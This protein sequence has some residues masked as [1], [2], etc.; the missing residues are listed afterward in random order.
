MKILVCFALCLSLM[1][2]VPATAQEPVDQELVARIKMESFQNSQVMETVSYISD[3]YGPRLTGSPALKSASEWAR[4]RMTQWGLANARLEQWGMLPRGWTVRRYSAEMTE[5]NY[6][7]INAYPKAWTPGTK[8]AISGTPIFVEIKSKADFEKYKG[9]LAGAI[10]MNGR[11]TI[12][13]ETRFRPDAKRWTDADLAGEAEAINP[14]EPASYADEVK[15]WDK[16]LSVREEITKFYHD[17][18]IA[19]L[20]EPSGRDHNVVRVSAESYTLDSPN[21][22]YPAMVVGAEHYGRVLRLLEKKVP[23]KLELNVDAEISQG[24]VPGYNVVAEIPGT[25]PK[26]KDEVV[27]LGGHLDSWHAGTGATDNAAG[28]AVM[29][30]A[31]R[32]LKTIGARPRRTIRVALWGGEEQDYY[33]SAGYVKQ[34]Y[35][36]PVTGQLKPE[37]EKLAAYYNL[38]NGSG[39]IRGIYLQGNET[40]RPLFE[41]YLRPFNYLGATVVSS[42][43]T[44]STDHMPFEAVGLPAFQFIQDD[45]DY[46]SRTHHS[47][48]DVYE[49]VIEDDLKQAAA[50]V[51]TFAYQTAMRTE[52]FPR[53][54]RPAPAK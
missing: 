54:P 1:P 38:D 28:C 16:M 35:G 45:L 26:L 50:V 39:K 43:N 3:V 41:A 29:M 14:G 15:D 34:H 33:G 30:E 51:A 4:D 10:V 37:G 22:T 20:L 40:A 44:G 12:R 19:M 53:K 9:K 8:G 36:D 23:V 21:L 6:M 11:P 31:V 25:D 48:A 13:Q 52:R 7:R 24:P 5:P 2:A 46:E 17:E 42:K 49:A 27:L 32:I 47:S 18:K